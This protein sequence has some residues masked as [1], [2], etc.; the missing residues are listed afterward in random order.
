M[1]QIERSQQNQEQIYEALVFFFLGEQFK[2]SSRING[3][4]FISAKPAFIDRIFYRVEIWVDFDEQQ[5]EKVS[6]FRS[7]FLPFLQQYEIKN[8]NV[9]F[10][11][12]KASSEEKSLIK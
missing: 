2:D 10:K 5:T 12:N 1:F 7:S 11:S 9:F 6:D 4:R 8:L 3:I